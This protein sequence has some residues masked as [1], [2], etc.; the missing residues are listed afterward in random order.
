MP[1]PAF[2]SIEPANDDLAQSNGVNIDPSTLP[3]FGSPASS[4]ALL[5][6]NAGTPYTWTNTTN[7]KLSVVVFYELRLQA[8]MV[9]DLEYEFAL[10]TTITG[11][12]GAG[13]SVQNESF[14]LS[15]AG[16]PLIT[17]G[18][19]RRFRSITTRA[20]RT[21]D[22]GQSIDLLANLSA[23]NYL[24]YISDAENTLRVNFHRFH[25]VPIG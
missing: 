23:R 1:K 21:V 9:P 14:N 13:F 25:I 11:G 20:Q 19:Y 10:A 5:P 6:D 15:T 4:I 24:P 3:E 16:H 2:I 8:H 7:R 17:Q 12:V 22:A 18:F